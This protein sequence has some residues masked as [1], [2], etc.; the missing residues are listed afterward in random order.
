MAGQ[1]A[2]W[3]FRDNDVDYLAWLAEHPDGYV[4]NIRRNN[5]P[6]DA[7]VHRAGCK[8]INGKNPRGRRLVGDYIKVCADERATLDQ[9]AIDKARRLIAAC[10]ACRPDGISERPTRPASTG[11]AGG[12]KKPKAAARATAEIRHT[13]EGPTLKSRVM[14]AWADEYIRFEHLPDWQKRLRAGIRERC[15]LLEPSA[16]E[17]LHASFFGDKH[18][19]ADVENLLLYYIGSFKV[20]GRNGIRFEHGTV[21]TGGDAEYGFG[22][23][24]ALA[25]RGG[26]FA[27]WREGEELA[28]F[29]P[30][31]LRAFTGEKKLAQVW[32][33]L[34]RGEATVSKVAVPGAPFGVRVEVRPPHR[35]TPVWGGLVKGIFDG[36]ICAFQT[37]TD[38]TIPRDAL[39]RLAGHLGLQTTG[40]NLREIER[41]LRDQDRN[42]LGAVPR[43]VAPYRSGVK[44]DPSDHL[45]VAGELLAV[46]PVPGED[47]WTI[48]GKIVELV[49]AG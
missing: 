4:L 23:R 13:I 45:C 28:S 42:V 38:P 10:G 40:E 19:R 39:E 8:H 20:P 6:A 44:W 5:N 7:R 9:W 11:K 16:T 14:Q 24:Y 29:G 32:W 22:Y 41:L 47:R 27:H 15:G 31:D 35:R 12:A 17:V 21:P 43:L 25:D 18:P 33:A 46:D 3:E 36:V 37:H 30:I 1:N 2:V 49:P 48:T 26:A 34:S